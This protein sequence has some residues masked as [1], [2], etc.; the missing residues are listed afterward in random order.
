MEKESL[1][2]IETV[3]LVAAIE[4]ADAGT[5]AARVIF[6]GYERARAG[7]ITVVFVGDVAAVRAAVTAG[8]VAA[9]RVGTVVSTHVIPRP[10]RQVRL[11]PNGR[12]V[13]PEQTPAPVEDSTPGPAEQP[14]AAVPVCEASDGGFVVTEEVVE[15][16]TPETLQEAE[17]KV[18]KALD[19]FTPEETTSLDRELES[20]VEESGCAG[21]I[22]FSREEGAPEFEAEDAVEAIAPRSTPSQKDRT[23]TK[24]KARKTRSKRK[25]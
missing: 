15:P 7:L 11:C 8:E 24:D 17:A 3:G 6:R 12:Q 9:K 21:G 23:K 18:E 22:E 10:D 4:A 13:T 1:G 14:G 20:I 25:V 5:K 2:L 19:G 16:T